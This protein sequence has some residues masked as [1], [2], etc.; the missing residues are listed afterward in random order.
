MCTRQTDETAK[1]FV[2]L[3][4]NSF[5]S[6]SQLYWRDDVMCASLEGEKLQFHMSDDVGAMPLLYFAKVINALSKL[7]KLIEIIYF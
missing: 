6:L 4:R 7:G 3:F 5:A 2:Q 1:P